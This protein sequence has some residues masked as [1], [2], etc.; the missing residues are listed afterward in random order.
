[1]IEGNKIIS[2]IITGVSL[3]QRLISEAVKKKANMIIVHHGFFSE[4]IPSPLQLKG[5]HRNRIKDILFNDINLIGYHLPLDANSMIGNNISL[6][7]LFGFMKVKQFDIGF[8]INFGVMGEF[9]KAVNFNDFIDLVNEKLKAKSYVLPFGKKMIRKVAIISGGS[10]PYYNQA[11]EMGADVFITGDIRENIVREAE[12]IE[13]N[14]INVGHY[15]TEKLGIQNLG[16]LIEK[17]FGVEVEFVDVP[18]EV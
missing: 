1:Q 4:T 12:E 7:K 11:C 14:I 13:I 18:N 9:K 16:K 5:I 6:A 15:N 10:S 3:S 17:K 8:G 2:K